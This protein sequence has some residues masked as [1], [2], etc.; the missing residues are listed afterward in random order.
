M[1]LSQAVLI[2]MDNCFQGQ[3]KGK[4][5]FDIFKASTASFQVSC[6]GQ[7]LNS[8]CVFSVASVSDLV[9]DVVCALWKCGDSP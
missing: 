2:P 8:H 6:G 5:L 4:F 3:S 1:G 7:Y 9:S